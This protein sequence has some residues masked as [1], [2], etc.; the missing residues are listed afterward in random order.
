MWEYDTMKRTRT[1]L[2]LILATTV[3][4]D[5]AQAAQGAVCSVSMPGISFG[6]YDTVNAV[7]IVQNLTLT[8][9]GPGADQGPVSF[10]VGSGTY[11][12]RTL[13]SATTADLLQY[14]LYADAAHTQVLGD[15][16]SGSILQTFKILGNATSVSLPIYAYLPGGQNV[17]P[18]IYTSAPIT[19]T[20]TY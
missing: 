13:S 12:V 17:A 14:N 8:C 4:A 7:S 6:I 5:A 15:G 20:V 18:G 2:V 11:A 1:L 19:V 9:T 3:M 10:S 16:T